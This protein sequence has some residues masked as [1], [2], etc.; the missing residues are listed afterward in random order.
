MLYESMD[1]AAI[2]EWLDEA[3]KDDQFNPARKL[4]GQ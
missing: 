3:G 2:C 4:S 1:L